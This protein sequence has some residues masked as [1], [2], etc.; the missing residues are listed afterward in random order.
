M[1]IL[2]VFIIHMPKINQLGDYIDISIYKMYDYKGL[3]VYAA[4]L[5][6]M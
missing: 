4:E 3:K 1:C 2:Y 6:T 5:C